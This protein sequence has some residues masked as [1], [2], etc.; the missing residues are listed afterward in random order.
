MSDEAKIYL[1]VDEKEIKVEAVERDKCI[2]I[3]HLFLVRGL[4][5][6]IDV[7]GKILLMNCIVKMYTKGG[8]E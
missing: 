2:D 7:E 6:E 1:T 3:T 4:D 8:T 5:M